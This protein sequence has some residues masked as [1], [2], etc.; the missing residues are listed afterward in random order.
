MG[1]KFCSKPS[2]LHFWRIGANI[3]QVVQ[4]YE[5]WQGGLMQ[6]Q[7]IQQQNVEC[8]EVHYE[9]LF[10]LTNCLQVITIDVFPTTIFRV[11]LLPYSY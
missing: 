7:N 5:E 1:W 4:N 11:G 3:L 2:K 6:L 8:V 10:E 9:C